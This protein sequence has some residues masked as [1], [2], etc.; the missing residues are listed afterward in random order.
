MKN[1]DMDELFRKA[2]ENVEMDTGKASNWDAVNKALHS[3]DD[4][5]V[6]EADKEKKKRRFFFWW[7]LLLPALLPAYYGWKKLSSNN[8]AYIAVKTTLTKT[9]GEANDKAADSK[10]AEN[11][12]K[13]TANTDQLSGNATTSKTENI[14]IPSLKEPPGNNN[15]AIEKDN[16]L[17]ERNAI[18][19]KKNTVQNNPGENFIEHKGSKEYDDRLANKAVLNNKEKSI[20]GKNIAANNDKKN[21][22]VNTYNNRFE[23]NKKNTDKNNQ[24]ST[25]IVDNDGNL[26]DKISKQH[27]ENNK[28]NNAGVSIPGRY[29][30]NIITGSFQ[31]V[32]I[33]YDGKMLPV[34]S[35][36][37]NISTIAP[38][39]VD[40]KAT[41]NDSL[42]QQKK[43]KVDEKQQHYFY[44]AAVVAPDLS[45]V[46]L[47][48]I[49]GTGSSV[50]LLLGYRINNRWHIETGAMWEK[51]IYYTKGENFDK[52]KLNPYLRSVELMNI[53]GNCHMITIPL[54]VRYNIST[55][56]KSNWFVATG[57]S[58]YLMN[59]EH[60]DFT[61]RHSAG[62]QPMTKG[63]DYKTP[64]KNW[65]TVINLNAGYERTF[66]KTFNFR[67]EP[68]FRIP[69]SKVGTG[70]LSLTSGGI[71]I[72][73]GKKF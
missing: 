42:L 20:S 72:G 59:K 18:S 35:F 39:I 23:K 53:D 36:E 12:G 13:A 11:A 19:N 6:E 16:S 5:N 71:Y 61:Y 31:Y 56:K 58:S 17:S 54:N 41:N 3:S 15:T 47:Q 67:I 34:I 27:I 10:P 48:R 25:S 28:P 38:G 7:F 69:V 33:D 29:A 45:S 9:A 40:L 43:N 66:L 62:G 44:I 2:A 49:A 55:G 1:D 30:N 64:E 4:F 51:K 22:S 32:F 37:K 70:N 52:S 14:S 60:Y 8:T 65:M 63:Y 73:I 21:V 46:K 24:R 26:N 50:G 68:Y 57:M